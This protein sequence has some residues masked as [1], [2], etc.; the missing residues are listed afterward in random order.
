MKVKSD[1]VKAATTKTEHS[2]PS[3][4]YFRVDLFYISVPIKWDKIG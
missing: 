2:G 1:A 4:E 3:G